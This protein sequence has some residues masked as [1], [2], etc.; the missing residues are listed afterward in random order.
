M[1]TNAARLFQLN[2]LKSLVVALRE[3]Y[4]S[5]QINCSLE[6]TFGNRGAHVR[7]RLEYLSQL[8]CTVYYIRI[9]R[10]QSPENL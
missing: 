7:I 4:M 1:N 5:P 9:A 10:K 6:A 3:G 8:R 2:K